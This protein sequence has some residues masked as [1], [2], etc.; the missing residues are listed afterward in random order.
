MRMGDGGTT[1]RILN[2]SCMWTRLI[3]RTW[4]QFQTQGTTLCT[5]CVGGCVGGGGGLDAVVDKERSLLVPETDVR[6]S[7]R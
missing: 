3:V 7:G 6:F 5:H 1:S 2:L 4:R